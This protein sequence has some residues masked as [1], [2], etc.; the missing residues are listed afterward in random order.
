MQCWFTTVQSQSNREH[1]LEEAVSHGPS[2]T[3]SIPEDFSVGALR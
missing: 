1:L 2:Q 3:S